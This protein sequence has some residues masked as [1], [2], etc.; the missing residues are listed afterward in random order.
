VDNFGS[1]AAAGTGTISIGVD[2][3]NGGSVINGSATVTGLSITGAVDGVFMDGGVG[4]IDNFGTITGTSNNG[5]EIDNYG[6]GG[7]DLVVNGATGTLSSYLIT[8]AND[9]VH[10]G[11]SGTVVNYGTLIGSVDAGVWIGGNAT[12]NNGDSA[13]LGRVIRGGAAGVFVGGSGTVDNFGSIAGTG[14]A[15]IGVQL[16]N[17]GTVINGSATITGLSIIGAVDGVFMHG[18]VGTIDNFGTITGTSNNGVEIDNYGNGGPDL[19]VNESGALISGNVGVLTG[20]STTLTNAGTITGTGGTAVQ[21]G[22]N[23]TLALDAGARFVGVVN[24][25]GGTNTLELAA[26]D[27]TGTTGSIGSS[28]INFGALTVDTDA[29]WNLT[30][31]NSI[32][33]VLNDGTLKVA[34]SAT[35]DVTTSIDV[36]SLGLFS[37]GAN[38]TLDVA[39]DTGTSDSYGFLASAELAIDNASQFGTGVGTTSYAGPTIEKFIAGDSIDLKDVAAAVTLDYSSSSGLLQVMSGTSALAT[40]QFQNATLG[41]GSFHVMDDG[42]GH[43]LITHS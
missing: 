22:G 12:V 13:D 7:P 14:T 36:G 37:L 27:G 33:T 15:S 20:G 31:T 32:L 6:N 18:G 11:A 3:Q 28:F 41:S 43:A 21:L 2:L 4:T 10:F 8:G 40:L 34:A 42:S 16:S 19:V 26:A 29:V 39:A 30:G 38:A 25:G 35:L 17:G 23:D 9:A 1:I 5:V 24:G